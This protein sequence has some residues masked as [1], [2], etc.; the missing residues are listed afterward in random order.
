MIGVTHNPA[1]ERPC[2]KHRAGRPLLRVCQAW[3]E[4]REVE[5]L[6]PDIRRAIGWKKGK[7][8]IARWGHEEAQFIF[9]GLGLSSLADGKR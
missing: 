2:A 6:S 3:H 5:V 9:A 7:G 8:V 4:V 1:V